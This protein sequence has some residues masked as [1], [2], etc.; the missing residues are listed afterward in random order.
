MNRRLPLVGL[1]LAL[2]ASACTAAITPLADGTS[3]PRSMALLCVLADGTQAAL[4]NPACTDS[5]LYALVGGGSKGT[6][7]LATVAGKRWY[8]QDKS[9]PGYTPLM[10]AGPPAAIAVSPATQEALVLVPTAGV[11]QRVDLANVRKGKL[12]IKATLPIG[13]RAADLVLTDEADPRVV[14]S[15]PESQQVLAA[16]LAS[17]QSGVAPAWQASA[18]AGSPGDLAWVPGANQLWVGHVRHGYVSVLGGPGLQ[19]VSTPLSLLPA[20]RNGLDD[21][22]D[23]KT[24]RD[25]SGCDH[26]N[27]ESEA[28]P[29]TAGLCANG[30]DDD[31]DG[32][33]DADDA[34]C[35]PAVAGARTAADACR[36]GVDD[37]GDGATDY[38]ADAGCSGWGDGSESSDNPGCANGLDDDADGLTDGAEAACQADPTGSE[39]GP[40]PPLAGVLPAC[41]N[42]LDDDDDGLADL[43]D[44]DCYNGRSAAE[45]G[46]NRSPGTL[47]TASLDGQYVVVVDRSARLAQVVEVNTL[48]WLWPLP[49]T[50]QPWLR[51]SALD[52]AQ[53]IRGAQLAALPLSVAPMLHD[54]RQ[55]VAIGQAGGSVQVL[56][57]EAEAVQVATQTEPAKP[58]TLGIH[59]LTSL[60]LSSDPSAVASAAGLAELRLGT[61]A[62]DL[63]STIPSRYAALAPTRSA[64]AGVTLS[65][66]SSSHRT[67]IWRL[68][69]EAEVPGSAR[70]TGHFV[71]RDQLLDRSADFCTMGVVA[72]DWLVIELPA[73][74]GAP[75]QTVRY[76]ISAVAAETLTLQ[77][78]GT[79]DVAVTAD[80]QLGF[81]PAVRTSV[82]LPDPTCLAAH[83]VTYAVRS[84]GWLVSG[85]RTGLLSRRDS[86]DGLCADGDAPFLTAARAQEAALA[87][88]AVLPACPMTDPTL[89]A[90]LVA[91]PLQHPVFSVQ[92]RPGCTR[93]ADGSGA[94]VTKLLPSIRDAQWAFVVSARLQPITFNLGSAPVVLQSAAPLSRLYALDQG[95]GGLL[96]MSIA[97]RALELSL[98]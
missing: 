80:N 76:P 6:L 27:D 74:G 98:E 77:D 68:T 50:Q 12:S 17:V 30:L 22:A 35:Q 3:A 89:D 95:S 92:L 39:Y 8:D 44:P 58:A 43:A 9:I 34:G 62:V 78:A 26:E 72:G 55:A 1:G 7:A 4:D 18:V 61:K 90:A 29:E 51:P 19:P 81:D 47:L 37:D 24:D 87:D 59:L 54:G 73:C 5:R 53:R 11:L 65:A 70:S 45:V 28:G 86:R 94:L 41:S 69:Y 57:L 97:G 13:V 75:K 32:Q 40:T 56:R 10:L 66:D 49:G 15:D 88:P 67:E 60:D 64:G 82:A 16:T 84:G 63:A 93:V 48:S 2:A 23:G 36:N 79:L 83:G 20:C 46:A 31:A 71:R 33:T 96:G 14:L 38:P 21:D 42:A 85:S 52:A 91:S 25:D